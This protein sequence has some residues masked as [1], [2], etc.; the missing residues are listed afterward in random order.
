VAVSLS[1][2][3]RFA[4]LAT[5]FVA[6]AAS[7][8]A[9]ASPSQQLRPDIGQRID[10]VQQ[11]LHDLARH[12]DQLVERYNQA[13]ITYHVRVRAAADANAAARTAEHRLQVAHDQFSV[14]AAAQYEGGSFSSTGALLDSQNGSSYL[15][16]LDT[17]SMLKQHNAQLVNNYAVAQHTAELAKTKAAGL[18]KQAAQS[19]ARL[20]HQRNVINRQIDRYTKLLHSLTAKQKAIWAAAQRAKEIT[21]RR[22]AEQ[23]LAAQQAQTATGAT[24]GTTSQTPTQTPTPPARTSHVPTASSSVVQKAIAFA[25]AQVGKPYVWGTA[26]PSTYDCSGLTMASYAAAGISLPHS[27][28]QQYGYGTHVS[29]DQL[30]PGDL[31]F[32]YSPIG[33]VTMYVGDGRMISA[34]QTGDVVKVIPASDDMS[35]FV[36]ATRLVG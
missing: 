3:V 33:H 14:A 7:V 8:P 1:R 27:A 36:G 9:I 2:R 20:G 30:Q 10:N 5:L 11:R 23:L 19:R 4:A 6:G 34:P 18:L 29:F 16:S 35:D 25:L 17:M 22:Q 21:Q 24:G 15:D 32:Y 28:A 12:N 26:G 13:N 31:M